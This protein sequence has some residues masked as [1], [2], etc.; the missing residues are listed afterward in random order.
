M[1][2][3]IS[4]IIQVTTKDGSATGNY[5]IDITIIKWLIY[6]TGEDYEFR[7]Y[8]LTFSS[9]VNHSPFKISIIDDK[10]FEG[11]EYFTVSIDSSSLPSGVIVADPSEASVVILDGDDGKNYM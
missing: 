3:G 8:S 2:S 5:N 11:N 1:K 9:N 7:S 6:I 4:F 10:I